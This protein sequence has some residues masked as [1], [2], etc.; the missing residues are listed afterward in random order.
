M[1]GESGKTHL[2][3]IT[4]WPNPHP[5]AWVTN[6]HPRVIST[7]GGLLF[8]PVRVFFRHQVAMG[9]LFLV[10]DLSDSSHHRHPRTHETPL[11]V[12]A[13]F[14]FFFLSPCG[15][16]L[17]NKQ[18]TNVS[19]HF[20]FDQRAE[21]TLPQSMSRRIASY[22]SFLLNHDNPLKETQHFPEWL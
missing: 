13:G 8:P 14:F 17:I 10:L 18:S 11:Q 2:G 6:F 15:I 12:A 7:R 5:Q 16:I 1:G 20:H 9:H 4:G 21:S 22:H 19:C 3:K